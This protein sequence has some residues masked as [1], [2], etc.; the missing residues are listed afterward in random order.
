MEFDPHSAAS[1]GAGLGLVAWLI[2]ALRKLWRNDRKETAV[3]DG[4]EGIVAAL[5]E[6]VRR[7]REDIEK[8]RIKVDACES[9]RDELI[10][11]IASFERRYGTRREDGGPDVAT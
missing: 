5:R 2:F 7:L 3:E 6:E 10:L 11:T 1:G 4:W 8:L 9:H